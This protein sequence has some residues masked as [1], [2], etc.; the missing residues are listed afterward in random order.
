LRNFVVVP[1]PLGAQPWAELETLFVVT[2]LTEIV[3]SVTAEPPSVAHVTHV[4][5]SVR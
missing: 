3:A 1:S 4:E 2:S 5:P